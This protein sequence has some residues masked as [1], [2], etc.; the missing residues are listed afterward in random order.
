MDRSYKQV[1]RESAREIAFRFLCQH[2]QGD[3]PNVFL[4]CS[5][6]GGSTWLLSILAAHPGVRYVGRPFLSLLWSRWRWSLPDLDAAAGTPATDHPY[7]HF[8]AFGE[9]EEAAFID[10]ARRVADG[11]LIVNPVL[12]LNAPYFERKTDRVVFQVT[13]VPAMI[14]TLSERVDAQPVVL[15]RHPIPTALSVMQKG[16]RVEAHD[17]LNHKG[18]AYGHLNQWQR[19]LARNIME[20]GDE[21]EK[22]V[23]DWSLKMMLPIRAAIEHLDWPRL[24]YEGLTLDPVLN[25]T[26]LADVLRLEEVEPMLEQSK[27][28]SVTVTEKTT[29]HLDDPEYLL[30]RWRD[31]VGADQERR[32]LEI[33]KEFGASIYEPGEDRPTHPAFQEVVPAP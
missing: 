7:E 11:S 12:R 30:R 14:E 13:H 22:H 4:Y 20:N 19:E 3:H 21:L 29:S 17:Y 25:I 18:F 2:R 6:R 28:A 5:R 31:K 9:R 26:A 32:L 27:R 24:S 10:I 16:W 33:T 1:L 8:I 15:V 23:L